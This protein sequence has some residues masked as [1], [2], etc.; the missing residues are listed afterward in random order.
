MRSGNCFCFASLAL[1]LLHAFASAGHKA[2][3]AHASRLGVKMG[4]HPGQVTNSLDGQREKP[5]STIAFSPWANLKLPVSLTCM[6]LDC[7]RKPEY[8]ERSHADTKRTRRLYAGGSDSSP[9]PSRSTVH[10]SFIS[11]YQDIFELNLLIS[12]IYTFKFEFCKQKKK[13]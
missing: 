1:R 4:L 3:E 7:G 11:S 5:P 9:R 2:A 8:L 10:P 13:I 6:P 12:H